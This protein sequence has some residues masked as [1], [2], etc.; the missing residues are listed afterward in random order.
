MTNIKLLKT[1]NNYTEQYLRSNTF[2][3][4]SLNRAVIIK[5][6]TI[7]LNSFQYVYELCRQIPKQIFMTR[8]YR[9]V[10]LI[11]NLSA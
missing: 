10:F 11:Y 7:H 5:K 3:C 2:P 6:N 1:L 4:L 9:S 8:T